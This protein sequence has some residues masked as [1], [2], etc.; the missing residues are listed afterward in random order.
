MLRRNVPIRAHGFG[1]GSSPVETFSAV[2]Q[3]E[4]W[5]CGILVTR[6]FWIFSRYNCARC[7][8]TGFRPSWNGKVIHLDPKKDYE[9]PEC[10]NIV[11][12]KLES[13]GFE[14]DS[15]FFNKVYKDQCCPR[16]HRTLPDDLKPFSERFLA[17]SVVETVEDEATAP[18]NKQKR[19]QVQTIPN[20]P[21][22][23][24]MAMQMPTVSNEPKPVDLQLKSAIVGRSFGQLS[25][26][27][28]RIRIL[29]EQYSKKMK[30]EELELNA[31]KVA[32]LL[33]ID[34]SVANF[35]LEY[36]VERGLLDGQVIPGPGTTKKLVLT[37]GLTSSGIE[38]VERLPRKDVLTPSKPTARNTIIFQGPVIGSNIGAGN[39]V[40][41]SQS[42]SSI[43]FQDL[44]SYVNNNLNESQKAALDP[45]LEELQ[46]NVK[47]D[48]TR[49]HNT[50]KKIWETM[51]TWGPPAVTIIEMITK[52]TGLKP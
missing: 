1:H 44:H 9:C 38:V 19:G 36:L 47:N 51:K 26:D 21:P 39:E 49:A 17:K 24:D 50:V 10:R 34:E 4:C 5:N 40:I 8:W 42:V 20:L 37:W 12:P 29:E 32:A 41:Q 45:L 6:K 28:I 3:P 43:S 11:K 16:C 22:P 30:G 13:I 2:E 52:M 18:P 33:G 31:Q 35:H 15:S 14:A 27:E 23:L 46:V 7:G 48:P 25:K